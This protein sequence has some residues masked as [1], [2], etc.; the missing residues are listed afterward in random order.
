MITNKLLIFLLLFLVTCQD[1]PILREPD[2][3]KDK[4][5][6]LG[7]SQK[8]VLERVG[9]PSTEINFKRRGY[10]FK[11]WSYQKRELD[12]QPALTGGDDMGILA[13]SSSLREVSIKKYRLVF[14]HD[15][16]CGIEDFV[17]NKKYR[18]SLDDFPPD[19][20]DALDE[21]MD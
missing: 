18:A 5:V 11:V 10:P 19:I 3:V 16:L 21:L 6:S 13:P 15:R 17:H 2:I 9:V 20:L 8:E 1:T 4:G 12:Y 14:I 7:N